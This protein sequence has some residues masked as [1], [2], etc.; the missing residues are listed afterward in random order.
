MLGDCDGER[1]AEAVRRSD[2]AQV[3]DADLWR[4]RRAGT[5]RQAEAGVTAC[6]AVIQHLE[7]RRRGAQNDRDV[8]VLGAGDREIARGVAQALLLLEGLVVFLVDDNQADF[9]HRR[10]HGRARADDESGVAVARLP[11]RAKAFD[12]RKARVQKRRLDAQAGPKTCDE[13]RREPDLRYQHQD[14]LAARHGLRNQVQVDLRLAAARD[15]V[16]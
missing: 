3:D 4:F 11:P 13:L 7:R 1:L 9:P 6:L 10:E 2:P 15:A 5:A 8:E 14:L 16:E 12:V